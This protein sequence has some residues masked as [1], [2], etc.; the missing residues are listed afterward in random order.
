[1]VMEVPKWR[2]VYKKPKRSS[3]TLS[4]FLAYALSAAERLKRGEESRHIDFCHS[5]SMQ[6]QI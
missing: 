4:L 3:Y 6:H 2:R 5:R 1:M